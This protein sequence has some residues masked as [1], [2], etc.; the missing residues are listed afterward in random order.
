MLTVAVPVFVTLMLWVAVPPTETLAKVRVVA[1]GVSTPVLGV[2]VWLF[3]A[4][5]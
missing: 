5:V 3:A 4:L 2:C 1:L